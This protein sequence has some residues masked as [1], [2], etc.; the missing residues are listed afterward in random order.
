MRRIFDILHRLRKFYW[1]TFRVRT[2]GVRVII[3]KEGTVCLVRHRYGDLWV[4]PGGKRGL[5]ETVESAARREVQ[6]ECNIKIVKFDRVLGTYR[7]SQDGRSDTVTV[8]VAKEWRDMGRK[9]TLEIRDSGFFSFA[10]LPE[11]TSAA[12]KRRVREYLTDSSEIVNG[13]W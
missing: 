11:T 8:L 5:R 2:A 4:F 3:P 7:N 13:S 6:E 10:E 1:R 12:T 9:W